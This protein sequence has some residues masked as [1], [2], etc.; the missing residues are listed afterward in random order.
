MMSSNITLAKSYE[1]FGLKPSASIDEVKQQYRQIAKKIHPDL[2]PADPTALD[3][4]NTL[5]QAYQLLIASATTAANQQHDCPVNADRD[6]T[7]TSVR[8]ND[9][10]AQ[11]LSSQDLQ[12]KRT[13][14]ENLQ[15]L[16][17]QDNFIAAVLI[18][19][20]LVLAIPNCPEISRK[21]SEIYF[22]Y[23]QDLVKQ[24][25]K[26]NIARTYLK[27]ALKIDPHNQKL[28]EAVNREFNRIERIIK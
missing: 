16:I 20:R 11:P 10:I 21:Q 25:R 23:A 19:D 4:F 27:A 26:L 2:N 9:P 12:L 17:S 8:T 15:Q 3:R 7:V 13:A 6:Y 14:F 18:I 1:L 22:K 28:W 5:N 24:R